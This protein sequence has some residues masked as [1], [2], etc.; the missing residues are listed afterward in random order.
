M[1]D[2]KLQRMDET[3]H[4]ME[5]MTSRLASSMRMMGLSDHNIDAPASAAPRPSLTT[6]VRST[7]HPTA[8]AMATPEDE[9]GAGDFED[10]PDID[11][12][13]SAARAVVDHVMALDSQGRR[14]Y[15][16]L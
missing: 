12:L 15:V 6:S 7:A 1:I 9:A 2:A 4:R 5:Q 8:A 11:I 16:L 3:C 13:E 14:R 10:E